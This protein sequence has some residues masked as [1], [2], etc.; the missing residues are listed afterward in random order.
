MKPNYKFLT[1]KDEGT[2][3]VKMIM[4]VLLGNGKDEK[5]SIKLIDDMMTEI[6]NIIARHVLESSEVPADMAEKIKAAAMTGSIAKAASDEQEKN[7]SAS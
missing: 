6:D 7:D 4:A 3:I 1:K 5:Q 2:I